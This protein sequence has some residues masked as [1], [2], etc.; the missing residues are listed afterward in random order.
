MIIGEAVR[1][2]FATLRIH[3]MRTFLT[4]FGIVWGTASLVFLLSWGEG[5]RRMLEDG[6]SRLGKDMAVVWAGRIGEQYTPAADRR[7]LWF[8][9][10]DAEA[11]GRR[12]RLATRVG[13]ESQIW[14]SP[15][16]SAAS[17]RTCAA[18]R[19]PTSSCAASHSPP[20][21]RSPASTSR[22]DVAWRS[23]G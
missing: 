5:L 9:R 18:W 23:W 14:S 8:T 11:L 15:T 2:S 13:A 1:Q 12:A 10:E 21:V 3:R 16:A 7:Y 19:S 4:L 17:P 22:T 6:F 20:G